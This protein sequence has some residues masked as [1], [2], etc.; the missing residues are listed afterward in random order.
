MKVTG[1]LFQSVPVTGA[2]CRAGSRYRLDEKVLEVQQQQRYETNERLK[3]LLKHD[4]AQQLAQPDK[5]K[6]ND[7][8]A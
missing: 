5:K 2:L 7:D 1:T 3:T 4:D 8:A 6:S